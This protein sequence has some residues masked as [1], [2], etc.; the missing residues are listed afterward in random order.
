MKSIYYLNPI[1]FVK[2][3]SF[4]LLTKFCFFRQGST[5]RARASIRNVFQSFRRPNPD[6]AAER[7][8]AQ[9]IKRQEKKE[10]T[11]NRCNVFSTFILFYECNGAGPKCA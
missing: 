9:E 5:P 6:D 1:G 2:F 11:E 3:S 7:D 10:K 4:I 8:E